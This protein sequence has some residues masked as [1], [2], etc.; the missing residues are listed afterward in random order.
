MDVKGESPTRSP[1]WLKMASIEGELKYAEATL[2]RIQSRVEIAQMWM[3]N[4]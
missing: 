2:R 4:R 1:R 3:G